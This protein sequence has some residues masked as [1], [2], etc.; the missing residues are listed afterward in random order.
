V[1]SPALTFEEVTTIARSA[2]APRSL[3]W[4]RET[5]VEGLAECYTGV[6]ALVGDARGGYP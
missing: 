4:L 1:D 2:R 6:C 3:R 5:L